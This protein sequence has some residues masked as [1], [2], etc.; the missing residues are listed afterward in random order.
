M[1]WMEFQKIWN[2]MARREDIGGQNRQD[3][4]YWWV[5][6]GKWREI[7]QK[8]YK[9][10]KP[11]N[12]KQIAYNHRSKVMVFPV[13]NKPKLILCFPSGYHPNNPEPLIQL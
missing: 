1:G 12:T 11:L 7:K 5:Y 13:S 6:E 10:K 9:H 4:Q 2:W 8:H 3:W